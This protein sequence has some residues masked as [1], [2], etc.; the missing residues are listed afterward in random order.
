M[1]KIRACVMSML[2]LCLLGSCRQEP[3]P[4]ILFV[5]IDTLR[6][7]SLGFI[8]GSNDTPAIDALASSGHAFKG[9][10]S[11]VPLTLPAHAS[12]L[13]GR[14]PRSHGVRDNGQT[15][16]ADLPLLQEVLR[17]NG[18]A[19]SAFVSGFPLQKMFGLDRGF[20]HYDDVMKDGEQGW[21]ERRAED[22]V[23][24]AS[25]W[26]AALDGKQPWFNWV[27]FYDPHDPYQPPREFWQPGPRG[28]YD[29][30]VAYTDYWLGKL[31]ADARAASKGGSLL[32]IVTSDHGEA[33]GEHQEKTHGFFVYD[34]TMRIPLLFDWPGRITPA[35]SDAPVQTI[36]I[37]PTV[38][39]LLDLSIDTPMDGISLAAGLTGGTVTTHPALSETWLPWTY[40]GWAPLTSWRDGDW[41]LIDAPGPELYALDHDP[42][43]AINRAGSDAAV[44][45]RMTLGLDKAMAKP[46]QIATGQVDD[47]AMERLRSLGYVGVGAAI[48]APPPNLPDP[49][50]NIA[51]RDALQKAEELLRLRR[52][53]EAQLL[54]EEVLRDDPDNRF[55]TLRSGVNLLQMGRSADAVKQF[56]HVIRID[57]HRAE[58]RFAL[59]DAL[60]REKQYLAA[61]EQWAA[62]AELQ[63]RRAEAWFNL[64]QALKLSGETQRADQALAEY[65]RLRKAEADSSVDAAKSPP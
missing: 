2:A 24:A 10:I 51:K 41:K 28:S 33:L 1:S 21:V 3:Q 58:A 50:D 48:T 34:S 6:P 22:T 27:H 54:F 25:S 53:D 56:Q 60:M 40:Y 17:R 14:L 38:L 5:T 19:T 43:E 23:A 37:M 9:A 31:I 39:E 36:D 63:P 15:V 65:E 59:G 35:L 18:Y 44:L 47:K 7:D 26:L 46:A 4:N 57:P 45:D 8:G 12:M 61:S 32:V 20:D 55:A 49:K 52:F 13:S 42:A 64:A 11:P 16:P 30:E 29:G 62:L